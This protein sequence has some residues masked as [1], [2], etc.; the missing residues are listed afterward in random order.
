MVDKLLIML[1]STK[2]L[3][4]I[5]S[6]LLA[7]FGLELSP[8]VQGYIISGAGILIAAFKLLD[9]ILDKTSPPA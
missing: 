4:V 9:S 3:A 6:T 2:T 8:D 5:A 1:T 7:V